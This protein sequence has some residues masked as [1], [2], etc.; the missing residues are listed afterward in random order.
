MYAGYRYLVS[1]PKPSEFYDNR[2]K[3]M[4]YH[5]LWQ[6]GQPEPGSIYFITCGAAHAQHDKKDG[7]QKSM[8]NQLE[9][10]DELKGH[11]L[12][13]NL[14][15]DNCTPES[16]QYGI[17]DNGRLNFMNGGLLQSFQKATGNEQ[18]VLFDLTD[19]PAQYQYIRKDYSD[20]LIYVKNGK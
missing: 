12:V 6:I 16:N 2:N 3:N 5:V 18:V 15:C 11:V 1:D 13:T 8:V 9:E 14:Y 4:A 17:G 19:L 7:L 10:S 20:F